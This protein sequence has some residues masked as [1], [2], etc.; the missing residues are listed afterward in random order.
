[1]KRRRRYAIFIEREGDYGY[2]IGLMILE[3]SDE[4]IPAGVGLSRRFKDEQPGVLR[5]QIG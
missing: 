5:Q 1:M 3:I 4:V 2:G